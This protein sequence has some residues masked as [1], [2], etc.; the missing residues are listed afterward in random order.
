MVGPPSPGFETALSLALGLADTVQVR[1]GGIQL[2]AMF[3]DEGFGSLGESDLDAVIQALQDLQDGGRLVGI[4]SLGTSSRS[5]GSHGSRAG[6]Y[7]PRTLP[8]NRSR[9]RSLVDIY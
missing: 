3:V 8:Q 9:C 4:I 2:D 6:V 7:S 1:S 5:A